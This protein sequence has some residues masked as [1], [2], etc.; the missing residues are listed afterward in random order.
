MHSRTRATIRTRTI[1]SPA[2]PGFSRRSRRRSRNVLLIRVGTQQGK[3]GSQA[4]CCRI[5]PVFHLLEIAII[6]WPRP[7]GQTACQPG[8]LFCCLVNRSYLNLN[9]LMLKSGRSTFVLVSILCV[10]PVLVARSPRAQAQDF[11]MQLEVPFNPP[12]VLPSGSAV[13]TISLTP[14]SGFTGSVSLS[15]SVTPVQT[16]ATPVCSVSPTSTTPPSSP[17]VTIT[18]SSGTPPGS[19]VATITATDG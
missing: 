18:T 2:S 11:T 1:P 15:C 6:G 10:L 19:Y 5:I 8:S 13:A 3:A 9:P 12:S 16:T 14:A 4:P 7:G 17:S